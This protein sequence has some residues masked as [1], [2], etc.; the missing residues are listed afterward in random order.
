MAA[1]HA[2]Q[3][4]PGP[5]FVG[6]GT[7]QGCRS[8]PASH[9]H[10]TLAFYTGGQ[11][12]I[13]QRTHLRLTPGDVLLI[14]AG[15]K[16]RTVEAHRA[17]FVGLGFHPSAFARTEVGPMLEP[18]ERVRQ[19]ASAV[20]PIPSGRQEH[21]VRLLSEIHEETRAP[22]SAMGEQVVR[23]LFSLVLA[24][25]ARSRAWT[26]AD[27]HTSWVG[28]ALTFIE[29]HCLERLSLRE[30]AAA[31]GRSPAHVTT[32][33]KQATGHSVVE[34]IISGRL[35]EARRRLLSSDE[36]VDIIAERV[37]YADPTHFIRLFRRAEGLTP[38]AWRKQHRAP[39]PPGNGA[40]ISAA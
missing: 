7:L 28:E 3:W 20:V 22:A 5:L 29:R 26:G 38:A 35:A 21:L 13:E 36:R 10:A 12:T 6:R 1:E 27:T 34:W 31:V 16:H 30:V 23:S 25:V 39:G 19:G 17:E 11:A 8:H 33:V 32:A 4:G 2:Q 18:F 40:S 15:E 9:A 37:G 24:E 14:P